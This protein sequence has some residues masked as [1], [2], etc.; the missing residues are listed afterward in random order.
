MR[1]LQSP[2]LIV[3]GSALY[4]VDSFLPWNRACRGGC[5]SFNLW[6]GFVGIEAVL[7]SSFVLVWQ[8]STL[9]PSDRRLGFDPRNVT[10]VLTGLLLFFTVL[11]VGVDHAYLAVGAWL[12]LGLA[13]SIAAS[14]YANMHG[15]DTSGNEPDPG[16]TAD[17]EAASGPAVT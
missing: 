9:L 12:G 8:A 16:A 5:L 6:H 3:A 14:G 4:L 1:K 10:V 11:K 15:R 2:V 17:P 7:A 13:A